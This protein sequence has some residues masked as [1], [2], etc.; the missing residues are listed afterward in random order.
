MGESPQEMVNCMVN[1]ILAAHTMD[2][3]YKVISLLTQTQ[4]LA[5]N[6]AANMGDQIQM[7]GTSPKI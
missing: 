6:S 4:K 1:H 7:M 5:T 3:A 2:D